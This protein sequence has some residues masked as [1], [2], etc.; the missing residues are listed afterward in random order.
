MFGIITIG[1]LMGCVPPGSDK[2][3]VI[4]LSGG[5]RSENIYSPNFGPDTGVEA[6]MTNDDS[7]PQLDAG[8]RAN[9]DAAVVDAVAQPPTDAGMPDGGFVEN[10]SPGLSSHHGVCAPE[11]PEPFRS[12]TEGEICARWQQDHF[13]VSGEWSPTPGS[14]DDC[15]PGIV[16]EEAHEN[17]IR[18]TNLLRWLVGLDPITEA[19]QLRQQEQECAVIQDAIGRLDHHPDESSPCWTAE[20]DRGAGSSNLARGLSNIADTIDLYVQDRGVPSLGHRRWVFNPTM[21]VTTFGLKRSSSCMY[22]F[23]RSGTANVEFWSWPPPGHVPTQAS[24]GEWS[25]VSN[26]YAPQSNSVVEYSVNGEPFETVESRIVGGNYGWGRTMAWSIPSSATRTAG[27]I[28]RI[29]I[30]DTRGGDFAY[31]VR[32]VNCE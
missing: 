29:R 1:G 8:N 25:F 22:S 11:A 26:T 16:S 28:I 32:F 14:A 24:L 6:R 9:L 2:P 27:S 12:R 3:Q 18:R 15:D 10:C 19:R 21:E 20:G 23:S 4:T 7:G 30:S 31:T 17:G 13:R 5:S